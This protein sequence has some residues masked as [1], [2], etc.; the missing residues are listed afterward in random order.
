[1]PLDTDDV[2]VIDSHLVNTLK[3][4]VLNSRFSKQFLNYKMIVYKVLTILTGPQN[5][6]IYKILNPWKMRNPK[7]INRIQSPKNYLFKMCLNKKR[8]TLKNQ[9]SK[10]RNTSWNNRCRISNGKTISKLKSEIKFFL[11]LSRW[12]TAFAATKT[13]TACRPSTKANSP[14]EIWRP[15]FCHAHLQVQLYL[16][17]YLLFFTSKI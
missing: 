10:T 8:E 6:L 9:V 13:L 11:K 17:C 2:N 4:F 12:R 1:M 7:S 5:V 15:D 14:P 3:H 16:H